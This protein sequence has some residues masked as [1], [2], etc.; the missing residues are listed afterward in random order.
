MSTV[1]EFAKALVEGDHKK[2]LE[3]VKTVL[4]ESQFKDKWV[5][6]AWQGWLAGLEKLNQISL[7][8]TLMNGISAEDARRYA[9]YLESLG[10]VFSAN[11]PDRAGFAKGFLKSWVDLLNSYASLK[12]G[13]KS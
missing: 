11:L 9:K 2:A 10:Q 6:L 13:K 12:D 4:E 7:I 5:E 1:E 8:V 3:I